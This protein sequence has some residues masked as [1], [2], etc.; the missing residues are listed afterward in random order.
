MRR[1]GRRAVPLFQ[2]V[3]TLDDLGPAAVGDAVVEH[4]LQELREDDI[5]VLA[6]RLA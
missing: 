3:E 4:R 6:V 5:C 2:F 1:A